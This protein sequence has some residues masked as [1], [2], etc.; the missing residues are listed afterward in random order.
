MMPDLSAQTGPCAQPDTRAAR[1]HGNKVSEAGFGGSFVPAR[2]RGV[3]GPCGCCGAVGLSFNLADGQ[4]VRLS[5]PLGDV[6]HLHGGTIDVMASGYFRGSHLTCFTCFQSDSST[7]SPAEAE[8][9]PQG[10]G[11]T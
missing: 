6:R 9:T 7:G 1:A 3:T 4:I 2:W 8:S 11:N 10:L 5:V